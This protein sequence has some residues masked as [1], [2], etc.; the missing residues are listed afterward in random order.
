[1]K[2][3]EF[4]DIILSNYKENGRVFPWR[5]NLDPWGIM[6]S[7]FMLQQTQTE[8]VVPYWERWME[9]WPAPVRL[10]QASLEDVLREWSGLGYN[11][12]AR[13]LK[14]T[15]VRIADSHGGIVPAS[16]DQLRELPGIG[17]Y[18]SQAI[19]C[20][21]YNYPAVFIETNIRAVYIHFFFQDKAG[22]QDA[23]IFPLIKET[24]DPENPREWYW[25]LMDYGAELKKIT[26]NPSRKSAHYTRQ[27]RFEGSLR[28][29][30]GAVI[31]SLVSDGP[32]DRD[33]LKARTGIGD[34]RL[35][36]ALSALYGESMVA[37]KDGIYRIP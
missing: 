30:R 14:E 9:R 2:T 4:K 17:T 15:A 1:M 13:Y 34:S 32:C 36:E 25:G 8:R 24:L 33:T 21:A 22:I 23:E 11:R 18:S 28:Q 12:R 10:A 20:F 31:R 35:D 37:E 29:V 6:V 3:G 27:S 5:T 19:A 26:P 16:P 7:E